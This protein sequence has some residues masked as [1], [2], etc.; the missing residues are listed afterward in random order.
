MS[1][2]ETYLDRR[3]GLENQSIRPYLYVLP[4]VLVYAVFMLYPLVQ[5]FL[6]SFQRRVTLAGKTKWV[7]LANYEAVLTDPLFWHSLQNTALFSLSMVF[8]PMILGLGIAIALDAKLKG[9]NFFRAAI[10]SPTV[11]PIVVSGIL[12]AWI[13]NTNGILNSLLMTT[14]LVDQKINWLGSKTLALP[15]VMVMAIWRRTGYYMVIL[16]AG[17]Q[18]I[19]TEVYEAATIHGKSRWETFRHVTVPL[20]RPALLITAVLGMIDT[21]KL[22]AHV[23]VMTGGGPA[24]ASQIL[25]TYFYQLTFRYYEFGKGA[26]TAFI[27][28]LIALALSVIVIRLGGASNE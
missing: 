5:A 18:S 6:L 12:F 28:F 9:T 24:N 20:L 22:F 14:G 15:S 16:L 13:F 2:I 10:F 17:L 23:Y 3:L 27:L 4:A 26:A 19:P 8:I 1:A 11:V 7:G 21:V 25:S